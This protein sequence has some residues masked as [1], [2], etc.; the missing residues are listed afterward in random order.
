MKKYKFN[1]WN[2][3]PN[4]IF[5]MVIFLVFPL[6]L[7]SIAAIYH[8][9]NLMLER[10]GMAAQRQLDDTIEN[11]DRRM[12][13][14]LRLQYYF[15]SSD[16]NCIHLLN[17][18]E[19][20][21]S[22]R[23]ARMKFYAQ[24]KNL[25]QMTD[26]ADAYFYQIPEVDFFLYASEKDSAQTGQQLREQYLSG[27]EGWQ[28]L[29]LGDKDL[30]VY[31]KKSWGSGGT[32][33]CWFELKELREKLLLD[34]NYEKTALRMTDRNGNMIIWQQDSNPWD[35]EDAKRQIFLSAEKRAISMDAAI[36]RSEILS[37]LSTYRRIAYGLVFF[38]LCL[39][40]LLYV[41]LRLLTVQPLLELNQ[42]HRELKNGNETYRITKKVSTEEFREAF[43]SF[44]AM[45]D[46]LRDYRIAV[47]E[48]ELEKQ[49]MELM[50]LQLQIRPH[51]LLNTFNLMYNLIK[52][53]GGD[54]VQEI[55]LYLSDYFRYMFR[56][57]NK[58]ELFPKE[59]ELIKGYVNM[60]SIRY[61]GRVH[62][63]YVL[64]PEME[65]LRVP[66]LLIHNFVENAVKYGVKE[67]GDLHILIRGEYLDG[68]VTLQISNDGNGMTPDILER[69]RKILSGKLIPEKKNA[70]LGL[71][72][73][74]R[75]LK[76][77]YGEKASIELEAD[78]DGLTVFTIRFPYQLEME[79]DGVFVDCE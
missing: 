79:V 44:N 68:M 8:A 69:N 70:H 51:F 46:S 20:G 31:I 12:G 55:I 27:K 71:Y 19:D 42:A 34:L 50:N 5:L 35:T 61:F 57:E 32:Y 17:Q 36:P 53:N 30:L 21:Y 7:L 22:Y 67:T 65:Y 60:A 49:D 23:N 18:T 66:P 73:S 43:V 76:Y 14:A 54:A 56:S 33:G 26:G 48:K 1:L 25:A 59:L 52:V 29:Q 64:D 78:E 28:L 6:N 63:E 62:A 3:L 45:A 24:L 58:K 37:S 2:N 11:L 13:N 16:A 75:R 4:R 15:A 38:S 74:Y 77:F 40:P 41:L 39:T 72:N 10:S 9:S 47:Y